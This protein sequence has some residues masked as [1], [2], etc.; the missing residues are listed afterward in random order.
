M[1]HS[2]EFDS[3]LTQEGSIATGGDTGTHT[4]QLQNTIENLNSFSGEH[5]HNRLGDT[6]YSTSDSESD[7]N[8]RD[9]VIL[10]CDD[11][12]VGQLAT[13]SCHTCQEII[14]VQQQKLQL[15]LELGRRLFLEDK[16]K[17]NEKVF[18]S[19]RAHT[20]EQ[21]KSCSASGASYDFSGMEGRLL[22]RAGLL[23][24]PVQVSYFDPSI[25]ALLF[26]WNMLADQ[27][28]WFI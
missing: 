27:I 15:E 7:E 24:E 23:Q 22:N 28:D 14:V 2:Q 21:I 5:E 25:F 10:E 16:Q 13:S 17:R 3:Q 8:N 9:L 11:E 6:A 12:L 18:L 26:V 1:P 19:S 4:E 20:N